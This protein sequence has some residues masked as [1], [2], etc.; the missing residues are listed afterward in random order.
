MLYPVRWKKITVDQSKVL[1][2]L[3]YRLFRFLGAIRYGHPIRASE[4]FLQ[5]GVEHG[6]LMEVYGG[7][8]GCYGIICSS[9]HNSH[10]DPI[11]AT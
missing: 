1:K 7:L 3:L 10:V 6:Y 9:S 2:N 4:E 5:N 11:I 8:R